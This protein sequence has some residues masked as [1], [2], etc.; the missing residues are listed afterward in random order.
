MAELDGSFRFLPHE[1]VDHMARAEGLTGAVDAGEGF[2]GR[3]CGVPGFWG[4]LA[5]VTASAVSGMFLPEIGQLGLSA[6]THS[7]TKSQHGVEL[8]ATQALEGFRPLAALDHPPQF[9][10]V[11]RGIGHPGRGRF[12]VA[13]GCGPFPGNRTPRSWGCPGLPQ[14]ARWAC[15]CPCRKRWWPPWPGLSRAGSGLGFFGASWPPS[16]RDADMVIFYVTAEAENEKK[17]QDLVAR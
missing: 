4:G 11:V 8:L 3:H 12:P 5:V 16:R 1:Y 13:A 7:F 9:H 15:R 14:S 17:A 6:A 10:H 2:L